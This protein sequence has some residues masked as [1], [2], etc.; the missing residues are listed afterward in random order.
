M[1][2][3]ALV[4]GAC[5]LVLMIVGLLRSYLVARTAIAPLI[6][7]GDPTRA[8]IEALRPLPFRPKFRTVLIRALVSMGWLALSLYGLYLVVRASVVLG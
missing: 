1:T 6:H 5:G 8:A 3:V 4:L 2:P 7:Q